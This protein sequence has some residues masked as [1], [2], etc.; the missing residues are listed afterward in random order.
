[1]MMSSKSNDR[2]PISRPTMKSRV[3]TPPSPLLLFSDLVLEVAF[4]SK[5]RRITQH[6][7]KRNWQS[8]T[9]IER[10]AA[11]SGRVKVSLRL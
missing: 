9:I 10:H 8:K 11:K 5:R 1:M 6:L 7:S 3:V 4:C 2:P